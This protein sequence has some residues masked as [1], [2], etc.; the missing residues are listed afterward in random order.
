MHIEGTSENVIDLVK[1]TIRKYG[2]PLQIL[3]DHASQFYNSR[4]KL[5]SDFDLFCTQND[6]GHVMDRIRKPTI[7]ISIC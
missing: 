2:K 4:S 7:P 5:Q 6:I 1:R 3:T